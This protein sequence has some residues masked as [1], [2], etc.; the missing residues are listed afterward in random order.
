MGSIPEL[1][2]WPANETETLLEAACKD[3]THRP[4]FLKSLLTSQLV[5][6]SD[7]AH[8]PN[9]VDGLLQDDHLKMRMI[10]VE[11]QPA[12][13]ALTSKELLGISVPEGTPFLEM[14][15]EDLFR[16]VHGSIAL[17]PMG[18]YGK[19]ITDEERRTILSG[20]VMGEGGKMIAEE[21]VPV[22]IAPLQNPSKQLLASLRRACLGRKEIRSAYLA[23][24]NYPKADEDFVVLVG[25]ECDGEPTATLTAISRVA[26]EVPDL[27]RGVIDVT[28]LTEKSL[29]AFIRSQGLKFYT[30]SPIRRWFPW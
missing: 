3:A 17:N 12:V 16:A 8:P 30:R 25:I 11:G 14:C 10:E 28:Q 15:G 4:A 2:F 7:P 5:V 21:E 9:V 18:P 29:S 22:R 1:P 19:H 23:L 20:L 27:P 6:L 24:V 26:R 13:I